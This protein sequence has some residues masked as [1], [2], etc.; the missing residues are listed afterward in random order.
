MILQKK[1]DARPKDANAKFPVEFA[2]QS[3]RILVYVKINNINFICVKPHN[4]YFIFILLCSI[5][6]WAL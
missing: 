3:V 1:L 2:I 4:L 6:G 5:L